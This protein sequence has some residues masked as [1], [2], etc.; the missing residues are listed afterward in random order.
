ML[1][2]HNEE[3]ADKLCAAPVDLEHFCHSLKDSLIRLYQGVVNVI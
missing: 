3:K 1:I 2:S